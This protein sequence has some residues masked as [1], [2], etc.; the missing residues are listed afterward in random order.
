MTRGC[1]VC[2]EPLR[3]RSDKTTCSDRCRKQKSRE[4]DECDRRWLEYWKPHSLA[5][6]FRER[7]R[8]TFDASVDGRNRQRFTRE[9]ARHVVGV[10]YYPDSLRFLGLVSRGFE[11]GSRREQLKVRIEIERERRRILEHKRRKMLDEKIERELNRIGAA[12]QEAQTATSEVQ[13]RVDRL[14]ELLHARYADRPELAEMR[15][16]ADELG[17]RLV[18]H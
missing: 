1:V 16:F 17:A 13:V 3:G 15:S 10:P 12:T 14:S 2:G 18:T 4:V 6:E 11:D 5:R 7:S 9:M 8:A